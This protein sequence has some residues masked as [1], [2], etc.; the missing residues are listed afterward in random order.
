M[1]EIKEEEK[2][3]VV[4]GLRREREREGVFPYKTRKKKRHVPKRKKKIGRKKT[5]NYMITK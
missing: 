2:T 1:K 5:R 4:E 3:V